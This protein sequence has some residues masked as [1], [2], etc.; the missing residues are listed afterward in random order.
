MP[1]PRVR[2]AGPRSPAGP[3]APVVRP[4]RALPRPRGPRRRPPGP[5]AAVRSAGPQP[6][7]FRGR[8][9]ICQCRRAR[10]PDPPLAPHSC[11]E[12]PVVGP[13]PMPFPV[14]PTAGP[15]RR[16]LARPPPPGGRRYGEY[17]ATRRVRS[18]GYCHPARAAERPRVQPTLP[19]ARQPRMLGGRRVAAARRPTVRVRGPAPN[20][21]AAPERC[22]PLRR[23]G[24]PG[25]PGYRPPV[26]G[27]R[28]EPYARCP[29]GVLWPVVDG[30]GQ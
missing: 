22:R 8:H 15:N 2:P 30:A 27:R 26:T 20:R 28:R 10:P 3:A 14:P 25:S 9:R 7:P 1:A 18:R 5:C 19:T 21:A 29:G 12:V 4:Q 11:A 24:P 17:A 13:S 23:A 16:E 6:P